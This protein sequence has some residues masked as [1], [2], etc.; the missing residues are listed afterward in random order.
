MPNIAIIF[1]AFYDDMVT[2][3]EHEAKGIR[4]AGGNAVIY[5]L[6]NSFGTY[7]VATVE[8]LDEYDGYLFGI[9]SKFGNFPSQ[10][11]MFLDGT[12]VSWVKGLLYH[13]PCGIFV[14]TSN[15][16]AGQESAV[17]TALSSLTH[18]GMIFFPLGYEPSGELLK[19]LSHAHGGS[20]W[21][22]GTF[23]N[24]GTRSANDT[25][26]SM[27]YSQGKYFYNS[28]SRLKSAKS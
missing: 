4:A 6:P 19:D 7:P 1:N 18:H 9:S 11:R 23:N 8:T 22:A 13:K 26:I 25:E 16:N 21:G 14:S 17:T 15:V 5:Q 27:A 3:A 28:V 10:W 12:G 20:P 24:E 2:M